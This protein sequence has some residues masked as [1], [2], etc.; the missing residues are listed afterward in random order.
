[1]IGNPKWFNVRKYTGWGLTP[2]CWQGWAYVFVFALPIIFINEVPLNISS[3]FK[4]IFSLIWILLL[5]VD[6]IHMMS[7]V[8]KDERERLHE[9]LADR[10]ALWFMMFV[11]VASALYDSFFNQSTN[12]IFLIAVL[13]SVLVKSITQFYL[14]DK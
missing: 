11:L 12:I 1:M 5:L 14:R 13:G 8:K 3:N 2:N 4:N 10:N 6:V 7:Q 9:A